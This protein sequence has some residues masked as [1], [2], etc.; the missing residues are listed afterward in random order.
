MYFVEGDLFHVFNRGNNSQQ[1]FF[2]RDNYLF[3]L[4]KI[5][6]F[7]LPFADVLAWCLMPNHFHLM[8]EVLHEEIT[9]E[10]Y[11]PGDFKSPGEYQNRTRILN[12]S[13]AILLRSYTRAINKQQ[14]RTGALFQEGTKSVCLNDHELSPSYFQTA[15]GNV[16]N[17]SIPEME[18]PNVCFNYIH[19]NPVKDGLVFKPE[20]WEFSSYQDYYCN[21]ENYFVNKESAFKLG[22]YSMNE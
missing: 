18:Y 3:F 9:I 4:A 16:G 11:S 15:Y 17:I 7:V 20:N 22:L 2:K 8:I 19:Q 6:E 10:N 14:N 12:N 5:K 21:R 1:I 13:I